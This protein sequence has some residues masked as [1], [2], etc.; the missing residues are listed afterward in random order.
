M[1]RVALLTDE[2][3]LGFQQGWNWRVY[4]QVGR[5]AGQRSDWKLLT[6]LW[7]NQWLLNTCPILLQRQSDLWV[8]FYIQFCLHSLSHSRAS[9]LISKRRGRKKEK[10]KRKI[11]S[12][13]DHDS[14][15]SCSGG[16]LDGREEALK[17]L[18][19]WIDNWNW[20]MLQKQRESEGERERVGR[21]GR[22]H[23]S[24]DHGLMY[25]NAVWHTISKVFVVYLGI[26]Y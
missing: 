10:E 8:L 1:Y 13:A 2:F 12:L 26:I 21:R 19:T 23:M 22:L 11:L 24:M 16:G 20:T 18:G 15:F 25:V 17:S 6:L 9:P 7:S 3:R 5:M 14:P 4:R